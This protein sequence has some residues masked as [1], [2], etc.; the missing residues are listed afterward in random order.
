MLATSGIPFDGKPGKVLDGLTKAAKDKESIVRLLAFSR[1]S[2]AGAAARGKR[3]K[4][5]Q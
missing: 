1:L 2:E 5:D 4:N 3:S